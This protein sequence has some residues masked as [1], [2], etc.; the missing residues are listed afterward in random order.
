MRIVRRGRGPALAGRRRS[1]RLRLVVV[2]VS[3]L[4]VVS[5][6]VGTITALALHGFLIDR[7]D[8]SLIAAES[9]SNRADRPP[10]D[11]GGPGGPQGADQGGDQGSD[12]GSD[13]GGGQ[14]DGSGAP[15]GATPSDGSQFLLAPGQATGTFGARIVRGKVTQV[16]VLRD[17]GS[18]GTVSVSD[19]TLLAVPTDDRPHTVRLGDL[20]DFRVVASSSPGGNVLITGLPMDSVRRVIL[21]LVAIGAA[22]AFGAIVVASLVGAIIVRRTLRPLQRVAATAERVSELPL[23][24][25]EV[26]ITDRIAQEDV[27]DRTEV[28]Q[29]GS[30]FNR[31]LDHVDRAL[32]ERHESETKV[33]QFVADASH[34]L[35]TPL[36]AIRG[37]AELTRRMRDEA[38]PQI[39]YAMGR[40][41][42]EAARMTTM[43]EDLLLLARLDTGPE[44][45][46][47]PV[48]LT[49]LLLDVVSDAIA[50]EP[51]HRWRTDLPEEPVIVAGDAHSLHQVFANLL[52][53]ARVHTPMG[54]TVTT[55]LERTGPA[56]AT[57]SIVDDGPGIPA[58]V[59]PSVFERFARGEASRSRAKGS[60]GL[61]LAIVWAIV[62]AHGGTVSVS[63]RPGE[64]A[65]TVTM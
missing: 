48:D 55:R 44:L 1:L 54:T 39:A 56:S 20:G 45:V 6:L 11:G 60:T 14:G 2:L 52:A 32:K 53:N 33:R 63:S 51:G 65:F 18:V 46:M 43:V 35:R 57:V 47:E 8:A 25:G 17:D 42:S 59:L 12:Q 9:R 62:D 3:L 28:G 23:S 5:A 4:A 49:H 58:E 26:A 41:E 19:A 7:L 30:S 24:R 61:G 13:Q 21:Q 50:S 37:Y 36:A 64:T 38:P 22:V 40:V 10:D 16:G 34:E 27:D 31:L 15:G 29:V